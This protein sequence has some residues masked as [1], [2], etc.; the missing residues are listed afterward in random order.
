MFNF[1]KIRCNNGSYLVDDIRLDRAKTIKVFGESGIV[2]GL[3]FLV[4][5]DEACISNQ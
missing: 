3:P 4:L 1:G 2:I 5:G